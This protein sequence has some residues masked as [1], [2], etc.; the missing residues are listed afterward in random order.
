MRARLREWIRRWQVRLQFAAERRTGRALRCGALASN[1]LADRY[2]ARP[3]SHEQVS[4]F[5]EKRKTLIVTI[6][7]IR[8]FRNG[9]QVYESAGVQPVLLNR[10]QAIHLIK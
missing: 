7:E 5:A 8:P 9:W 2:M 6:I 1:A 3:C 4:S 10:G